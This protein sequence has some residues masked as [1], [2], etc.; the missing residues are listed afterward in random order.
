MTSAT[1][2]SSQTSSDSLSSSCSM[3][4]FVTETSVEIRPN[5]QTSPT[6]VGLVCSQCTTVGGEYGYC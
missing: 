3:I 4:M 6:V 2:V 1:I 5:S